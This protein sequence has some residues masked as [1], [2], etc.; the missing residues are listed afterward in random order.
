MWHSIRVQLVAVLALGAALGYAVASAG[1]F[2]SR[3]GNAGIEPPLS[4][5]KLLAADVVAGADACTAQCSDQSTCCAEAAG[6]ELLLAQADAAELGPAAPIHLVAQATAKSAQTAAQRQDR[7]GGVRIEV[8]TLR[9]R[10]DAIANPGRRAAR[11]GR[12]PA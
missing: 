6:R 3:A 8:I 2:S 12:R 4:D 10:H 11:R 1:F 5:V 9:R 7:K